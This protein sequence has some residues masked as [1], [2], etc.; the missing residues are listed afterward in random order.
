MSYWRGR[1]S[2]TAY[3]ERFG[4]TGADGK[5]SALAVEALAD[6][7]RRETRPTDRIYVFGFASG[8]VY[9]KS[10]R[11]SSSRFFWSRPVVIEFEAGTPGYGSAGL[12]ADLERQPPAIVALQKRD[13]RIG[14]AHVPNSIEFFLGHPALRTWLESQYVPVEDGVVFAVWRRRS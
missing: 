3:L 12:L 9:A 10:L 5:F 8:G 2:R 6:L 11:W 1:I 7:V 4:G 13:W 14:E